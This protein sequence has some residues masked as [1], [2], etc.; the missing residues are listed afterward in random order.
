[1]RGDDDNRADTI[2]DTPPGA[3]RID[4]DAS[5]KVIEKQIDAKR[6]DID[7]TLNALEERFSP[8]QMVDRALGAMRDNGGD[9]MQNLGRSVRDNPMPY[10]LT[11][12][13]L[14][15]AMASSSGGSS[16]GRYRSRYG[17]G[18]E[19][20]GYDELDDDYDYD[21]DD[22]RA[23]RYGR[24]SDGSDLQPRY[25][26][27]AYASTSGSFASD[28][29]AGERSDD[30]DESLV[31]KAKA[32]FDEMG[33]RLSET[34]E[35]IADGA[36]EMSDEAARRYRETRARMAYRRDR[37]G[38]EA[39]RRMEMMRYRGRELGYRGRRGASSMVDSVSDLVQEQPMLAGALGAAVGA[40]IGALLPASDVEDRYLGEHAD[41][42]KRHARQQAAAGAERLRE[43]AE[44]GLQQAREKVEGAAETARGKIEAASEAARE[45]AEEQLDKADAKAREDEKSGPVPGVSGGEKRTSEAT[46]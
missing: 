31:D 45:K 21:Y 32:K 9:V 36:G 12:I 15:W 38:A 11:G 37:A 20:Y 7:R 35:S 26:S 43:E 22:D 19:R 4:A 42:A 10:V 1:M 33:N 39:R 14:V 13:G 34:G 41:E 24:S 8:G 30:D 46:G 23:G 40:V 44:D 29:R 16:M 18:D 27:G 25:S 17:Y 6:A 2:R 5:P 28:D 3:G